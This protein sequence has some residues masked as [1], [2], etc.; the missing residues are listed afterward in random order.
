[1]INTPSQ[2]PPLEC[3]SSGAKRPNNTPRDAMLT[4]TM[5]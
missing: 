2:Q 1:M 3:R 4:A 5:E